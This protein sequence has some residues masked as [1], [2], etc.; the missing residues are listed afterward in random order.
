MSGKK[1]QGLIILAVILSL[2]LVACGPQATPTPTSTPTEEPTATEEPTEE[3]TAT[4]EP[5]E[6][7]TATEELVLKKGCAS[8]W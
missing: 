3:P 7:P 5:T 2:V 8:G 1:G 6:E 4:E